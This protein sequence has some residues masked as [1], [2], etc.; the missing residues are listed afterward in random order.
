ML[1][2][3]EEVGSGDGPGGRRR[4]RSARGHAP[5]RARAAERDRRDRGRR[6]RHDVLPGRGRLHGED[7]GR[8]ARDR[9]DRHHASPTENVRR[10]AEALGKTPREVDVVV[11][12]RDRHEELIGE[13]R[14]G[15]RA[16]PADP[17]RRRRA[18]DR[19]RAARTRASTCS[20]GSAARPR[21]SSP[22][23][24]SSA[25]AAA[26]RAGS[27]RGTTS[28]RQP[29][30]AAGLDPDARAPHERPRRGRGRLRRRDG[31]DDRRAAPR[32]AATTPTARHRLDRDALPFGHGAPHRGAPCDRA[33][34]PR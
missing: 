9:R 21:A 22:R 17:R 3:G 25:S 1:Y 16:R 34:S 26:S 29:L 24:R 30:V 20:T 4:R 23:L 31:R 2:N 27:G 13:L 8:A 14:A 12:E 11:L 33:S 32:R 5:H 7:R 19:R 15:G 6:A 18:G 28:E 10:V